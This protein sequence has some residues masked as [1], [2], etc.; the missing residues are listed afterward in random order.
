MSQAKQKEIP[1]YCALCWSSC[2]CVSVVEDGKLVEVLT[3]HGGARMRGRINDS[4]DPKVV[5]ATAGWWQECKPLSLE[6]YDAA[7]DA[8]ANYNRMISNAVAD[9]IGG[10]TPNKSY[11]C[12]VGKAAAL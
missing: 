9:P 5:R 8:G 1:G 11:L 7:S 12:E 3:P 2:G 4:L 6:G 10:C